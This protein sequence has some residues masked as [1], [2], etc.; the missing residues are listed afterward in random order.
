MSDH[1]HIHFYVYHSSLLDLVQEVQSQ[2]GILWVLLA[3]LGWAVPVIRVQAL[4]VRV[5][6]LVVWGVLATARLHGEILSAWC[7]AD[8]TTLPV[9]G[10]RQGKALAR[11][12]E[13]RQ[14]I[15]EQVQRAGLRVQPGC[16]AV[17]EAAFR[18]VA[19]LSAEA[20]THASKGGC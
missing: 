3:R 2:T 16:Y 5:G 19:V 17:P 4:P 7:V 20:V 8:Q 10:E 13:V 11:Q 6:L 15:E 12:N 9:G 14:R 18:Q 1:A